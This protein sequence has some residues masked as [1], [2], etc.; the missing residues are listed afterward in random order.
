MSEDT[1]IFIATLNYMG[2]ILFHYDDNLYQHLLK[3]KQV[4]I[5]TDAKNEETNWLHEI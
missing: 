2:V 3:V 5:N 1:I 4:N